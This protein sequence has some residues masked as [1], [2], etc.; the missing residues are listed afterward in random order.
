MSPNYPDAYSNNFECEWDIV[1]EEGYHVGLTFKRR[2]F[3]EYSP[4]CTRDFLE[5]I[6]LSHRQHYILPTNIFH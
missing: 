2:F 4:N 5:V 6:K 1:V 3:I